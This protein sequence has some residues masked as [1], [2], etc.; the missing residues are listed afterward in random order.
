MVGESIVGVDFSSRIPWRRTL[1]LAA[2]ID[3]QPLRVLVDLGL[4]GNYINPQECAARG[5]KLRLKIKWS[6]SRW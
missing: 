3:Y 2:K 6:S 1:E 4:T 5:M